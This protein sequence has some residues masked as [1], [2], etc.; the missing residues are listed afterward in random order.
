MARKSLKEINLDYAHGTGHGVGY[1]LNVHEGPQAISK[2]NKVKF[3]EGMIVSNEP[4]YYENGKFGIRI[5]NLIRV[6]KNKKNYSFDNLTMAPIDKS[7]IN[8][9]ILKINEINWLNNYHK[10]VFKNLK[11][12]MNMSELSDLKQACSEI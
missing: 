2:N 4:G 6:K 3:K 11:K 9:N 7:L 12:F 5:E 8:K 10:D 1:F